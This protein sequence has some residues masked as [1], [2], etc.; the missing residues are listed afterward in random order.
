MSVTIH[1]LKY[2]SNTIKINKSIFSQTKLDIFLPIS[3]MQNHQLYKIKEYLRHLI[4][5]SILVSYTY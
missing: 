3:K 4:L 1:Q 5:R 2:S